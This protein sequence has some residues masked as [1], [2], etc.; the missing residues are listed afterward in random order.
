MQQLAPVPGQVMPGQLL[1]VGP[2]SSPVLLLSS[3]LSAPP[4]LLLPLLLLPVPLLLPLELPLELPLPL[5][6]EAS[7][8]FEGVEEL[9]QAIALVTATAKPARRTIR[10]DLMDFLQ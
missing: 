2:P 9:P 8:V 3:P 1:S 7:G 4:L 5:L 10:T 6:A